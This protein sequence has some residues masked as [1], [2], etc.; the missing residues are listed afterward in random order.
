MKKVE[1]QQQKIEQQQRKF[2]NLL[3]R[4]QRM[5]NEFRCLKA[6][7]KQKDKQ[8]AELTET[9]EKLRRLPAHK[10][11]SQG[12]PYE[13]MVKQT[14]P[15]LQSKRTTRH[16]LGAKFEPDCILDKFVTICAHCGALLA[17]SEPECTG[18]YPEIELQGELRHS[19][20]SLI[21]TYRVLFL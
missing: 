5:E 19:S 15:K 14:E 8:N 9:I 3:K 16:N 7:L 11:P 13:K 17:P 12:P 21:K 2:E 18:S 20:S 6:Q 1:Q 4:F 10:P